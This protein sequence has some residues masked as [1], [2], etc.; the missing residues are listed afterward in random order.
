MVRRLIPADVTAALLILSVQAYGEEKSKNLT[1]ARV[2]RKSLLKLSGRKRIR[3]A[4]LEEVR[5]HAADLGWAVIDVDEGFGL[6]ETDSA[7]SWTQ[8]SASRVRDRRKAFL[9]GDVSD[10][11]LFDEILAEEEEEYDDDE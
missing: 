3:E 5:A 2:S 1:R 11:D 7:R 8:V 9:R 10:D 4:F 6:L